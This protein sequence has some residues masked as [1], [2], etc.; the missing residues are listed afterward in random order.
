MGCKAYSGRDVQTGLGGHELVQPPKWTG[1]R[2]PIWACLV[3]Q[4]IPQSGLHTW[5]SV[6]GWEDPGSSKPHVLEW[7]EFSRDDQ[8]KLLKTIEEK[9]HKHFPLK[10]G[11]NG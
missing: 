8:I 6:F 2:H 1:W 4:H 10:D 3:C 11:N 5:V 9:F 7:S